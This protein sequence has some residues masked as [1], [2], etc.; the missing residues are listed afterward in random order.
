MTTRTRADQRER[1][2]ERT[3]A[4][5]EKDEIEEEEDRLRNPGV[6][7]KRFPGIVWYSNATATRGTFLLQTADRFLCGLVEEA[8]TGTIAS[9]AAPRSVSELQMDSAAAD[10]TQRPKQSTERGREF[11]RVIL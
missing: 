6:R 10:E 9:I 4:R 3:N 1:A 7:W 5:H 8:D 11:Q 2:K